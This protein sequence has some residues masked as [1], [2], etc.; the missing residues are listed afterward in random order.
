[1][2]P[3]IFRIVAHGDWDGVVGAGLFLRI[4]DL[5]LEFPL[6][7]LELTIE[8]AACIEITPDR[9]TSL[10]NSLIIDHHGTQPRQG[11]DE[12]GNQWILEPE[13]K[14]V[15]SLIADHWQL[16]LPKEWRAAV[17]EVDTATLNS[18]LSQTLW[19][20]YRVDAQGF[21]RLQVAEMVKKG[22]W[23]QLQEWAENRQAEYRKVEEKT[24][25][26]L[27]KSEKLTPESVYFTFQFNDR[28]ERGA[29]KD[30][31]L[32]LEEKT[33]IVIAIGMNEQRVKSGTIATNENIDLTKIYQ[34]LKKQGYT[35]GGHKTV[36]GFQAL[37]NK[38]LEQ[39]LQDL[40][41][42]IKQIQ[43]QI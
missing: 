39:A 8:N 18:T 20:A 10:R 3:N 12:R 7:L 43:E 16:E 9:V 6:E 2:K 26:L 33:P 30:V 22:N 13:Y 42:A 38:T 23:K 37:K 28:W 36:G 27:E 5:P 35:S 1:M 21:P 4:H 31:M 11:M 34:T 19:K 17:E 41:K 15:S 32:V 40:R 24:K 29:S 25:E 14:A